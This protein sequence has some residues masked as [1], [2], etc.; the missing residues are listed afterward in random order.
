[1]APSTINVLLT[2]FPGLGLP[3]TLSLPLPATSTVAD[4]SAA[5][6]QRIP[7]IDNRL[8]LT[9]NSNKLLQPD[10]ATPL[11]SLLSSSSAE[12]DA[13]AFLSLRLTAP[14]CGGKG[15]F[16]SQLRAAGGRMRKKRGAGE[17]NGS[18]RNLDGRRLRTVTEAKALAEYLAVKPEMDQKQKEERRQRW[19]EIVEMAERKEEEILKGGKGRL[20][21][22]W[23]EAK[24][25]AEERTRLAVLEAMKKG[26]IKDVL[27]K[28]SDSSA[29]PSEGSEGSESEE[30]IKAS[31][32]KASAS[33]PAA[34]A[35]RTFFGWDDDED[36]SE[37]DEDEEPEEP[38]VEGK[39]K[40][41]A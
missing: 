9:T 31:A 8:I 24:E 28:E 11:S 32:P 4:F 38:E 2:S 13:P 29:S 14:L 23:V 30:E 19:Q 21:G 37:D 12:Q 15:G 35:N 26:D 17:N 7:S 39:G 16:G 3:K 1:M 18:S 33:K 36:M 27:G 41:K 22:E 25:E 6:T 40:A 5:L 34:P 20:N 10:S